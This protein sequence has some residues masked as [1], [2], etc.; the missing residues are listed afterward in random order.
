MDFRSSTAHHKGTGIRHESF[1]HV[2]VWVH[3]IDL[4]CGFLAERV[5][6]DIRNFIGAFVEVD[7]RN[8]DGEW[9]EYARVRVSLDV[10]KPL[11]RRMKI[12]KPG[13]DWY[14]VNFKYERLPTFCYHCGRIMRTFV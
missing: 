2:D 8:F 7:P 9:K 4:P 1:L 6:R 11:K 12:K 5:V 14:W 13:G 10:R 3:I